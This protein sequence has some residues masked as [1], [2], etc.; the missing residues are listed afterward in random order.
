VGVATT[1]IIIVASLASRPGL[2]F[3]SLP[4]AGEGAKELRYY[5]LGGGGHH[6][7]NNSG[8]LSAD[9]ADSELKEVLNLLNGSLAELA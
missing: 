5:Y 9:S 2:P 4:L 1:K 7:D 6:Q 3:F 8:L